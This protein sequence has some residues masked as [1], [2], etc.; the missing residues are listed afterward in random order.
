MDVFDHTRHLLDGH[1]EP[2]EVHIGHCIGH[3][4]DHV[5]CSQ[6]IDWQVMGTYHNSVHNRFDIFQ[7]VSPPYI[8]F[9]D[10]VHSMDLDNEEG[11]PHNN[12]NNRRHILQSHLLVYVLFFCYYGDNHHHHQV[13]KVFWDLLAKV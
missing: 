10:S 8:S 12:H 3:H 13:Q 4:S 5:L 9:Q 6:D 11:H 1:I 2:L 7:Q